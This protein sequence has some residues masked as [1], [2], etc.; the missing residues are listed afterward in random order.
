M[1]S[2]ST[3]RIS[4]VV[5]E[6]DVE[7]AVQA[8]HARVRRRDEQG[9]EV[10]RVGLMGATGMVGTEMLR[11]LEERAF[12]VDELRVYASPR[13]EGRKLPFNG[14]EV[15]VRGPARRLLRRPRPRDRRRRRADLGGVVAARRGRGRQG[16]RQ[17]V[18]VPHG[19][20]RPARRRRG[21]PRR[22]AQHAEGHRVVP[23]L[24]DDDPDHRARRRC[25]ARRASTAWSCRRTS[26]C[27]ARARRACTSSTRSGRSSTAAPPTSRAP[28]RSTARSSRARCG[29]S[30]SPAT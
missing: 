1:I 13:S 9:V 20:R 16:H 22:H 12:P 21:E 5:A 30:R 17:V 4:C 3:I 18:G 23:E 11:L 7:R 29:R 24:H 26:R 8:L 27:R 10:M 25:T 28:R 6:D 15:D 19:P 14:G 2:T